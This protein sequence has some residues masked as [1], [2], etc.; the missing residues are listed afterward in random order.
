[1]GQEAHHNQKE[2]NVI[3]YSNIPSLVA[4]RLIEYVEHGQ[5]TG[6]FLRAVINNDLKDAVG[7]AD[8]ES[9]QAL[10]DIVGW[11]HNFAPS[12]C[13]GRPGA[14]E[15]WIHLDPQDRCVAYEHQRGLEVLRGQLT[16]QG[17]ADRYFTK[18][19]A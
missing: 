2:Q 9:K 17:V 3:D 14:Y 13:W 11:L 16:Q 1:M 6:D 15:G 12:G 5:R 4:L 10:A 7:R 18:E 8:S 19:Q